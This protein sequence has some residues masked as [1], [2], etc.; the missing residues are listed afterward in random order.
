LL[1][2]FVKNDIYLGVYRFHKSKHGKDVDG[3][4]LT[5]RRQDHI[6]AGSREAPNHPP[7]IDLQTFDLA[8]QKL[9]TNR[10]KNSV[11]L[12]MAT[13]LLRRPVC[14]APMHVKYSRLLRRRASPSSRRSNP[15][16]KI[17]ASLT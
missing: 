9:A 5:I 6:V 14:S 3:S 4:R 8:Q 11:R 16:G 15:T 12:Y 13:G 17:V 1:S 10:K 2:T 7:L